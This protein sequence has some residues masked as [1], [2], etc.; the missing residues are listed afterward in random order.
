MC[1]GNEV[2]EAGAGGERRRQRNGRYD[3]EPGRRA[4]D[5]SLKK[6][7]RLLRKLPH[8]TDY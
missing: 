2:S 5:A 3:L 1:K 4:A 6:L 8:Q 7:I